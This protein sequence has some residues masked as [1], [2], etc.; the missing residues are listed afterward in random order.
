MNPILRLRFV[1]K[2]YLPQILVSLISLAALTGLSLIVPGIMQQVIDDGISRNDVSLLVRA[3]L[4]LLGLGLMTAVLN[5]F[6]RYISEWI[7]GHIGY[8]IRNRLYD[9]IQGL[10]FSFHDHAQTGQLISRCIEDVRSVQQFIGS[11]IVELAQMIFLLF[12]ALGIMLTENWQLTLIAVLPIF[13]LVWLTIRFGNKVTALFFNVD[14]MLGELSARLQENVTGAQVVRAFAREPHEIERFDETNRAYYDARMSVISSWSQVMPTTDFLVTMCTILIL[15]FGGNMVLKGTLTVG[16]LVAFNA[17]VL[18]LATPAQQLTWLVNGAGEASAGARRVLE[19]LDTE[20]EIASP[21]DAVQLSTLRG[22]VEFRNVSLIY[23]NEKTASLSNV[24][25][26]VQP[27]QL[28]A[29]IGATGSGKSSLINLIPRFYDVTRG[30]VLVDGRD[31]RTLDLVSLRRQIGI[32]LQ[33]SL[34]FSDSIKANIAYGH[35]DATDEEVIAAAKAAQ[36]HEFIESFPEGYETVVGERGVTLSGGQRQRVAIARALLMDPRILILDDSLSSVDTQTEKLIQE[37]LDKL[38]EGRTT[39]VIA[40]RLSTVRRADLIV[41]MD[42]GRI[43]QRGTHKELLE[44]GGL[45]REIYDLQLSQRG[46]FAD[47]MEQFESVTV[48]KLRSSSKDFN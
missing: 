17:Y 7:G 20:P 29:L 8:D 9:H 34:L 38:M 16:E 11:S 32:V 39:F 37:A 33:T 27:N 26:R 48:Q 19:V 23:Q 21:T 44:S 4:L 31:V 15:W 46:R 42:K 2:P 28:I 24:S 3:A 40:H 35:P 10:S 43:V 1:V 14:N 30:A 6:Q 25:L 13:P 12:G 22:E 47:E 41:V 5:G 18:M 36:A 45:Y